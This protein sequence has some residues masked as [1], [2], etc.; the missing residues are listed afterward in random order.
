ME[1]CYLTN[2]KE[3]GL[4]SRILIIALLELETQSVYSS[5]IHRFYISLYG[6]YF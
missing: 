1:L 5:K 6:G 2:N 3:K 4:R